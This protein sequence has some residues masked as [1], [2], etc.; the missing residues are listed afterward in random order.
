MPETAVHEN[1]KFEFRENKIW[2]SKHLLISPPALDAM[3]SE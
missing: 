2:F 3:P 1:D